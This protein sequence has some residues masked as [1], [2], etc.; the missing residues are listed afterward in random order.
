MTVR[1]R[2]VHL[3]WVLA[4]AV[5]GVAA[6]FASVPPASAVPY[7]PVDQE[8][9]PPPRDPPPPAPAPDGHITYFS[10]WAQACEPRLTPTNTLHYR[11]PGASETWI[12]VSPSSNGVYTTVRV[13]FGSA[14]NDVTFTY[15]SHGT[16]RVLSFNDG[17]GQADSRYWTTC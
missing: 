6:V 5:V 9:G 1:S 12:S 13:Y 10:A 8:C 2:H 3:R 11:A 17:G 15:Q 4:V 7:C 14:N 16:F